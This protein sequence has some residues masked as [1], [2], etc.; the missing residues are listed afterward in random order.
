MKKLSA[1]AVCL[2]FMLALTLVSCGRNGEP[3][4]QSGLNSSVSEFLSSITMEISSNISSIS[5]ASSSETSEISSVQSSR[6][7]SSGTSSMASVKTSTSRPGSTSSRQQSPPASSSPLICIPA[8]PAL[9]ESI[10]EPDPQPQPASSSQ[11]VPSSQPSIQSEPAPSSQPEPSEASP[12]FVSDTSVEDYINKKSDMVNQIILTMGYEGFLCGIYARDN[13]FVISLGLIIDIGDNND[14]MKEYL[15]Q[16]FDQLSPFFENILYQMRVE[17][18]SAKSV[19]V[20][21]FDIYGN[22]I[23]SREYK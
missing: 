2:V 10:P 8:Q 1:I 11:P 6:T 14:I 23:T 18:P 5:S 17:V 3:A 21:A 4:A 22:I 7:S 12:P 16:L 19:I 9:P 15:E 13:S 20:E